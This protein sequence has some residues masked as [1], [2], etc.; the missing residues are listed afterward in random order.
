MEDLTVPS[1]GFRERVGLLRPSAKDV[2]LSFASVAV[3]F[4]RP[5]DLLLDPAGLS[6]RP[7]FRPRVG[8]TRLGSFVDGELCFS[9]PCERRLDVESGDKTEVVGRLWGRFSFRRFAFPED[10]DLAC[11]LTERGEPGDLGRTSFREP[12]RCGPGDL[13]R[14]FFR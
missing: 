10:W 6:S 13:Q 4:L 3:A 12:F 8:P 14:M 9:P 5:T 7:T 1:R 11:F 2:L